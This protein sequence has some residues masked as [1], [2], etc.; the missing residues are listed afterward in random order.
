MGNSEKK[1]K[2]KI[3]ER[4]GELVACIEKIGKTDYFEINIRHVNGEIISKTEFSEK[5]KIK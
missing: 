4:A 3:V 2:E 5:E 1:L